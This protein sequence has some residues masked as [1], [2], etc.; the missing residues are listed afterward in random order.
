MKKLDIE[1][2]EFAEDPILWPNVLLM[3]ILYRRNIKDREEKEKID[4]SGRRE[5]C[6]SV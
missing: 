6:G 5:E 3:S 1:F 4:D 2:L